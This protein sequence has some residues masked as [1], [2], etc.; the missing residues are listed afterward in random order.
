MRTTIALALLAAALHNPAPAAAA[1]ETLDTIVSKKSNRSVAESL[2]RLAGLL[3]QKGIAVV[4]R[5][6]HAEAAK[7]SG[8]TLPPT[9]VLIFGKP[10]LGTPLMQADG[11]I[12]LDLPMKVL[13]WQD[14]SGAVW[15]TYRVPADLRRL[16]GISGQD[17]IFQSMTKALDALTT[18]AAQ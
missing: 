14:G 3:E 2:D 8:G 12:G 10:A 13:A 1:G 16:Y 11:R 17:A 5:I 4:A 9:Q 15:L 6:D 7:R 18:A